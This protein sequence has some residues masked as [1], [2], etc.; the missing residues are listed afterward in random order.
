MP[1]RNEVHPVFDQR[2]KRTTF[3]NELG[4]ILGW[5][6]G[7]FVW[8]LYGFFDESGQHDAGGHLI[9]LTIGG[10]LAS[11]DTWQAF[12]KDWTRILAN[13]NLAMFHATDNSRNEALMQDAYR[14]IDKYPMWMFGT[15]HTGQ[16]EGNVF[17]EA[18]GNCVV[19]LLKMAHRQTV[20]EHEEFQLVFA[21]HQD[22]RIAR[23]AAY[24]ERMQ[25]LL[26]KLNGW[27]SSRPRNCCPLQ[28][29][30]LIAYAVR[31]L[32]AGDDSYVR[33]LRRRHS[34]HVLPAP[35]S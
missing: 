11:F 34:F 26:P 32:V 35:R 22:F 30:D 23:I 7:A 2:A 14:T 3:L 27:S 9:R 15:T 21:E 10:A 13:H 12:E 29:S 24:C 19:D 17:K 25:E 6:S 8:M 18:Y 20:S 4:T 5:Q 16:N 1:Q 28:L 31:C 33:A